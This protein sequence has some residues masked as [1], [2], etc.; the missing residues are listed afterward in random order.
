M[1]SEEYLQQLEDRLYSLPGDKRRE[2][3]EYYQNYF[4]RAGEEHA[5][6]VFRELGTP[7]RLAQKIYEDYN[8]ESMSYRDIMT[9]EAKPGAYAGNTYK[10]QD[11]GDTAASRC[12]VGEQAAAQFVS[13]QEDDYSADEVVYSETTGGYKRNGTKRFRPWMLVLLI[14]FMPVIIQLIGTLMVMLLAIPLTIAEGAGFS[15]FSLVFMSLV[16]LLWILVIAVIII[17]IIKRNKR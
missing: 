9:D 13:Y 14:F 10:T 16:P 8:R 5:E 15:F 12:Q 11:E 6:L 17:K 7:E 4:D 1:T 3:I 2:I